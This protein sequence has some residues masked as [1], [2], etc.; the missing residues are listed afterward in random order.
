[1]GRSLCKSK[2]MVVPELREQVLGRD[3]AQ[4]EHLIEVRGLTVVRIGDGGVRRSGRIERA[5]QMDLAARL[6][7]RRDPGEVGLVR[8]VHRDHVVEA[9]EI[10]SQELSRLAGYGD[11]CA[12]PGRASPR[13]GRRSYVVAGS[14]RA[15]DFECLLEPRLRDQVPEDPL[16]RR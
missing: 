8:R 13:I 11:S 9:C 3:A 2:P 16:G 12:L 4:E 15:V 7:V 14:A 10:V 5:H 6:R 1:M